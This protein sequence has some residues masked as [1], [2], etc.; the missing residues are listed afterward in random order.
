MS[1]GRSAA[2]GFWATVR[3]LLLTA[4][5]RAAGRRAHQMALWQ[6]RTGRKGWSIYQTP[7]G[8]SSASSSPF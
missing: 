6:H 1:E 7:W 2:V 3:L 8:L 4:R 5:K